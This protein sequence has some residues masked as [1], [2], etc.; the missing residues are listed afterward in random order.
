[1]FSRHRMWCAEKES[2]F[3]FLPHK[4]WPKRSTKKTRQIKEI[5]W[6]GGIR[7]AQYRSIQI[8]NEL[9]IHRILT[10]LVYSAKNHRFSRSCLDS[11]SRPT[12]KNGHLAFLC[13]QLLK[14]PWRSYRNVTHF[15]ASSGLGPAFDCRVH[16]ARARGPLVYLNKNNIF[17][18]WK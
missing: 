7:R 8:H 4:N 12:A 16:A 1:M 10:L 14:S 6:W 13:R 18:R 15:C 2:I 11:R 9:G 17:L 5:S 3:A